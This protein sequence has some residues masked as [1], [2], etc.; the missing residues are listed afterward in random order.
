MSTADRRVISVLLENEPGALVMV[1]G[2]FSARGCNIDSL[3]VAVTEEKSLSRMTIISRESEAKISQI[4][5]QLNKLVNV[6]RVSVLFPNKHIDRE[7]LL[8]KVP[9]GDTQKSEGSFCQLCKMAEEHGARLTKSG[10][11]KCVFEMISSSEDIE[12]F[13]QAL[14][15][16][17]PLEVVRSGAI[18]VSC[19][20]LALAEPGTTKVTRNKNQGEKKT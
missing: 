13:A 16:W 2:L 19:E 18:S 9:C 14:S 11:G 17:H 8:A 10:A 12:N 4:I 15:V 5:K 1:A 3:T 20:D 7:M 6:V